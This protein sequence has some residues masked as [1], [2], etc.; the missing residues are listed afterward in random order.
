MLR[1]FCCSPVCFEALFRKGKQKKKGPGLF[2]FIKTPKKKEYKTS[3]P[4]VENVGMCVF[5]FY[6]VLHRGGGTQVIL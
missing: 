1:L 5:R 3:P 4:L 2:F 6:A